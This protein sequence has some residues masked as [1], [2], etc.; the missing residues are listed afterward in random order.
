MESL[1]RKCAPRKQTKNC[2]YSVI[3]TFIRIRISTFSVNDRH[4]N[5]STIRTRQPST[6]RLSIVVIIPEKFVSVDSKRHIP[7]LC[8]EPNYF[9]G[10]Y[11]YRVECKQQGSFPTLRRLRRFHAKRPSKTIFNDVV[12]T[13]AGKVHI[14]SE[15]LILQCSLL[16]E[17]T[18][19]HR[20]YKRRGFYFFLLCL[21]IH[22]RV[23][24]DA[25]TILTRVSSR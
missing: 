2:F 13:F 22:F 24:G 3:T 12:N 5:T 11:R 25:R 8:I 7:R 21:S 9:C 19:T 17:A 1:R 14:S 15:V 6:N 10:C 18:D 20:F 23:Q 4:E 16:I